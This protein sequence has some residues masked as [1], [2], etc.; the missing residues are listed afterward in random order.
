MNALFSFMLHGQVWVLNAQRPKCFTK[1][2]RRNY[3]I[4]LSVSSGR[5]TLFT[6]EVGEEWP[7]WFEL[8]KMKNKTLPQNI[9]LCLSRIFE[10]TTRRTK[11]Q[12][13]YGCRRR[14]RV[15]FLNSKK[16]GA[17]IC[18]VS[19]QEEGWKIFSLSDQSWFLLRHSYDRSRT[20]TNHKSMTASSL[21]AKVQMAD[22]SLIWLGIFSLHLVILVLFKYRSNAAVYLIISL[23]I[24][25]R[26]TSPLKTRIA[27]RCLMSWEWNFTRYYI[28]TNTVHTSCSL[29]KN[30]INR[31]DFLLVCLECVW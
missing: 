6:D 2:D 19:Q 28:Q 24:R 31:V 3:Y 20:W 9:T 7:E 1:N 18:E 12:M 17:R 25:L 26:C 4:L 23:T 8:I 22:G 29:I 10:S 5:N 21:V 27:I 15:P 13:G 30:K 14:Q 11:K 16:L